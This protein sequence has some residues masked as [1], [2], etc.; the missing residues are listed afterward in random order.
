M[1]TLSLR[2]PIFKFLATAWLLF[3]PAA[4]FESAGQFYTVG[5]DPT[6]IKWR[7]IK[8]DRFKLVY[9]VEMDSMARSFLRTLEMTQP[10]VNE[11]MNIR[12]KR[13]P[14]ILHPYQVSSN[15]VVSWA[16]KAMNLITSPNPYDDSQVDWERQLA[17]HEL[18]HVAQ[19][20]HFTD[21]FFKWTYP[22]FGE[23]VTG[24]GMGLLISGAYMEG[25]AVI[26][27][28]ELT[29]G[30][31]GRNAS[32]LMRIR[33]DYLNDVHYNYERSLLG[34][35][36]NISYDKYS[37]GYMMMSEERMRTGDYHYS[38]R[39]HAAQARFNDIKSLFIKEENNPFSSNRSILKRTQKIYTDWWKK[40]MESRGEFTEARRLTQPSQL[41]SDLTRGTFVNDSLSPL[42]GKMLVI[43]NGMEYAHEL[44]SVSRDGDLDH[45][46]YFSSSTSKLSFCG[47]GRVYWSETC[48]HNAS[49]LLSY[50][51]I[52]Y[53]DVR[54]GKSGTLTKKT[55]YFN[56]S[57]NFDGTIVAVAEYPVGQ[58]SRL[59]LLSSED[60]RVV[61]SCP[62]YAG[63]Q[64][65]ETAFHG[66]WIYATIILKDGVG[67]WKTPLSSALEGISLWENVIPVRSCEVRN[68]RR[69]SDGISFVS[70]IDGVMNIYSISDSG[71]IARR[72]NSRYGVNYPFYDSDKD[73][74]YFSEYDRMG[75]HISVLPYSAPD[76]TMPGWGKPAESPMLAEMLS[77]RRT[78]SKMV[79]TPNDSYMDTILAPSKPYNKFLNTFHIHSWA[80]VYVN[81]D[82]IKQMS[83]DNLYEVASIGAS[84][85]SQNDLGTVSSM[86]AYSYH[87]GL[88]AGHAILTGKMFNCDVS[89]SF[90]IND[91]KQRVYKEGVFQNYSDKSYWKTSLTVDYPLNMFGDGWEKMFIPSVAWNMN[92]D[93]FYHNGMDYLM[94]NITIGARY[95]RMRPTAPNAVFPRWGMSLS[96]YTRIPLGDGDESS[97]MSYLSGYTYFPG[98]IRPHGLKL[99]YMAQHN[100]SENASSFY[101]S[102]ADLPRGY[103]KSGLVPTTNYL[104]LSL[105]YAMP[106]WAGDLT[107]PCFLY[108][109]RFQLIPFCDYGLDCNSRTVT[110]YYSFGSDVTM[111]FHLFRLSFEFTLGL[112][113]AHAGDVPEWSKEVVRNTFNQDSFSLL[114]N[115]KI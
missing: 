94:Q 14:V 61:S 85:Y 44:M 17:S 26:S 70:D 96:F 78:Q 12:T 5:N 82:R 90:D 21:G 30:G 28:T 7:Q 112:R 66:G 115:I 25:D 104:K 54:T 101:A 43:R 36:H 71:S 31:R 6:D 58:P 41:Q 52:K 45:L 42:D 98:I 86:L 39:Y 76:T 29:C 60:G 111:Q 79:M 92:S 18:R 99:S 10:L 22:L 83:F 15:G 64:I 102:I 51:E 93:H 84:V 107:I 63:G 9:P 33:T 16:P 48:Y 87:D 69:T 97:S 3:L 80:P 24:L 65:Q 50:S 32:F 47:G 13:I 34:S 81:I 100:Y 4:F 53:Y 74:L 1:R 68:L 62:V 95:Y 59:V 49:T 106:I 8:T 72:T 35:Y 77:Q 75:Y 67:I 38:G 11:P 46:R 103:E 57:V 105:D 89:A 27:E 37:I 88:H 2:N 114:F 20:T 55:R 40:D 56:P 73:S 108:I 113:Y 19:C 109:K 110:N 91:R 23:M